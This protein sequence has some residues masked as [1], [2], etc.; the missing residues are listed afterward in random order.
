MG[1][2]KRTYQLP[3]ETLTEFERTVSPQQRNKV[4]AQLVRDWLDNRNKESLRRA[5]IEG[6]REM[7]DLYLE[8][9]REYHP[10]EEEVQHALEA[11]SQARRR[12]P[13]SSRPRRGV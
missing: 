7:A 12:G 1:T 4:I 11:K 10:L 2:M 8:I 3:S 9:E 6:C 5:V 13:R